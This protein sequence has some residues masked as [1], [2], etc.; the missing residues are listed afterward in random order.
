MPLSNDLGHGVARR[1]VVLVAELRAVVG[2]DRTSWLTHGLLE[3]AIAGAPEALA[4]VRGHI[5]WF[6]QVSP[7]TPLFLPPVGE[8]SPLFAARDDPQFKHGHQIYLIYQGRTSQG[9]KVFSGA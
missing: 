6:N 3:A 5:D 7:S 9:P 1:A 8:G 2:G 4:L